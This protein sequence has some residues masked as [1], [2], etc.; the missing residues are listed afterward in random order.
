MKLWS[1]FGCNDRKLVHIFTRKKRY[2]LFTSGEVK[3]SPFG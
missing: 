1:D 2:C 3:Y